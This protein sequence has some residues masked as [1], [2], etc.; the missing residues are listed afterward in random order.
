[1]SL[2]LDDLLGKE[3]QWKRLRNRGLAD[4]RCRLRCNTYGWHPYEHVLKEMAIAWWTLPENG[5]VN[6]GVFKA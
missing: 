1:M 3:R 2:V 4:Q 5:E 6:T